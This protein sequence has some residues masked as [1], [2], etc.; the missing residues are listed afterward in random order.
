MDHD[1]QLDFEHR[2]TAVEKGLKS[3]HHRIEHLEKQQETI[4]DLTASIKV[5]VAEQKHQTDAINETR[6]DVAKL[7]SKV[8]ALEAKPGKRWETFVT[9]AVKL[10]AALFIGY[11]AAK[12]GLQL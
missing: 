3:D 7:D 1:E 4:H 8:D 9:E 12:M 5:M 11:L 6:K 10:L 2:L